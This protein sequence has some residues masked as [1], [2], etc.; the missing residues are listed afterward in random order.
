MD[1][2]GYAVLI[3]AYLLV[4]PLA[5]VLSERLDEPLVESMSQESLVEKIAS[6]LSKAIGVDSFFDSLSRGL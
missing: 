3:S 5:G 6:D 2:I 1:K 4:F